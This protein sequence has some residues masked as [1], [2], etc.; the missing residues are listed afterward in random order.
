MRMATPMQASAP[1]NPFAVHRNGS[2]GCSHG[3]NRAFPCSHPTR[4]G[5]KGCGRAC[6]RGVICDL[7]F[8]MGRRAT[9]NVRVSEA[10]SGGR[11]PLAHWLARTQQS[12]G[13][14]GAGQSAG[15]AERS[16]IDFQKN[17]RRPAAGEGSENESLWLGQCHEGWLDQ[18]YNVP[19][20]PRVQCGA[21][22][23]CQQRLK[24]DF[25][26]IRGMES[27]TQMPPALI[28]SKAHCM[29]IFGR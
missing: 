4:P 3:H 29:K 17:G 8:R 25:W 5:R 21:S 16:T 20:F 15:A 22:P 14:S 24:R 2:C 12:G 19:T 28:D 18:N 27:T 7:R 26:H 23:F 10:F 11:P 1:L 13:R 9:S 6:G